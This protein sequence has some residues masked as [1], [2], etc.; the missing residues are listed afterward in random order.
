MGR[1]IAQTVAAESVSIMGSGPTWPTRP[2]AAPDTSPRNEAVDA[3]ALGVTKQRRHAGRPRHADLHRLV[4][5]A[6]AQLLEPGQNAFGRKRELADD[7]NAQAV[8]SGGGDL[9]VERGFQTPGRNARMAF[10]IGADTDLFNAGLA[11]DGLS[12]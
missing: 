5:T 8:R 4:D 6:G 3:A 2:L 7:M 10:R 11:Q 1:D 12:G 9:F